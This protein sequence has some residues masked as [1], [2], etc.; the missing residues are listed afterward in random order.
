MR[1]HSSPAEAW[2]SRSRIRVHEGSRALM[3]KCCRSGSRPWADGEPSWHPLTPALP[4]VKIA[5]G[6]VILHFGAMARAETGG[7]R[8]VRGG[9]WIAADVG[10]LCPMTPGVATTARLRW[11]RWRANQAWL[12]PYR[13]PDRQWV[14]QLRRLWP[15]GH[16]VTAGCWPLWRRSWWC[17]GGW[18]RLGGG[19]TGRRPCSARRAHMHGRR[20]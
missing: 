1:R 3:P 11:L 20:Q 2:N 9:T 17:L 15:R 8:A 13:P 4:G 6:P 14:L 12:R 7:V 19:S 10:A 18:P 16:G 5:R